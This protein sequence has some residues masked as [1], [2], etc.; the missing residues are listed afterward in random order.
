MKLIRNALAVTL[1]A[2]AAAVAAC[3]GELAPMH[4]A[5]SHTSAVNPGSATDSSTSRSGDTES[6]ISAADSGSGKSSVN[7]GS[8]NAVSVDGAQV[9]SFSSTISGGPGGSY[10]PTLETIG[11]GQP[12]EW[13]VGGILAGC[14]YTL[15]VSGTDSFG[16]V[17]SAESSSFCVVAGQTT[18]VGLMIACKPPPTSGRPPQP[19]AASGCPSIDS[20]SIS[21]AEVIGAQSSML[22][23]TTTGTGGTVAWSATC[24]GSGTIGGFFNP[25]DGAAD[26]TGTTVEFRC[27]TCNGVARA[28]VQ[29]DVVPPGQ[30]AS[31]NTCNADASPPYPLA[32]PAITSVAGV[33]VCESG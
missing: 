11:D 4:A 27:G 30:D 14:G 3:S 21:P 23:V 12:I 16:D 33:I 29:L 17:C 25:S 28:T 22:S 31:T 6:T 20:F 32:G 10:G 15:S 5:G 2:G 8:V 19:Q 9:Q 18:A 13:T 7:T 1:L 24:S 26:T